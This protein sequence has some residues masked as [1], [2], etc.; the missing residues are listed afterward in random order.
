METYLNEKNTL[1][2]EAG[3]SYDK[4]KKWNE[5]EGIHWLSEGEMSYNKRTLKWERER[6]IET[7]KEKNE[8]ARRNWNASFGKRRTEN[9]LEKFMIIP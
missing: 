1:F 2:R 9:T 8:L 3:K 4:S 5:M 7:A 6:R